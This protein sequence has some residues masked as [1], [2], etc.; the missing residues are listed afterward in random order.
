MCRMTISMSKCY[1][2]Q[3]CVIYNMIISYYMSIIVIDES[4][5]YLRVTVWIC[6]GHL[7]NRVFS[8]FKNMSPVIIV[9]IDQFIIIYHHLVLDLAMNR[10]YYLKE[11]Y[12]SKIKKMQ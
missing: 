9:S 5:A 3:V 8:I 1:I 2:D 6:N 12:V 11:I 10:Y 4:C 7:N